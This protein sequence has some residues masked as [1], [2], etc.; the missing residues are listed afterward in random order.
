[1][2][3]RGEIY[4]A[5]LGYPA[6]SKPAKRRPIL[7]IQGDSYNASALA[8]VIAAVITSNT[9][10]SMMPGNVFLPASSSGLQRDSVINITSLVTLDRR[11][12]EQRVG[13]I[14]ESIM[15]QV[16]AGLRQVLS[17]T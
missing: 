14:P 9:R 12:I 15:F 6:G 17:L 2:I 8:T 10:L 4:W 13:R 11:D 5:D 16:D 1:M 3:E 7:I